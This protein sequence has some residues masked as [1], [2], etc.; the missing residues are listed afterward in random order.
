[1]LRSVVLR[2]TSSFTVARCKRGCGR[3]VNQQGNYCCR[4]CREGYG[5]HSKLCRERNEGR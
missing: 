3:P 4:Q 2:L 5:S 1:M